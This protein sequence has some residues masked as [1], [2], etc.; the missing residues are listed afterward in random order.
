MQEMITGIIVDQDDIYHI[1]PNELYITFEV[2]MDFLRSG[3]MMPVV[4]LSG[5]AM[6]QIKQFMKLVNLEVKDS[7]S[8]ITEVRTFTL[9]R[10]SIDIGMVFNTES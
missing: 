8:I 9:N 1:A 3:A 2:S 5:L 4:S 6:A 7:F 10:H